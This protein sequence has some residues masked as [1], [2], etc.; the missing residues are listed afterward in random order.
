MW[1]MVEIKGS[2]S[3]KAELSRSCGKGQYQVS[4]R[5]PIGEGRGITAGWWGSAAWERER[6]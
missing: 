4:A 3:D 2:K 5:E 1:K 6:G